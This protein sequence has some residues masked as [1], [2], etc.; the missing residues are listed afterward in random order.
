M[1]RGLI[2][3]AMPLSMDKGRIIRRTRQGWH[4]DSDHS[5][6]LIGPSLLD[7]DVPRPPPLVFEAFNNDTVRIQQDYGIKN[8]L[9]TGPTHCLPVQTQS[10]PVGPYGILHPPT[11]ED[12]QCTL[13]LNFSIPGENCIGTIP[14]EETSFSIAG[15]TLPLLQEFEGD[16][17][18][19]DEEDHAMPDLTREATPDTQTMSEKEKDTRY[20]ACPFYKHDPRRFSKP[21]WKSCVHP[22]YETM[23]RVKLVSIFFFF[24][25]QVSFKVFLLDLG[26]HYEKSKSPET[27]T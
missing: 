7:C 19:E 9:L 8:P 21:K 26:S 23:H 13:T 2:P 1:A 6:P 20:L 14:R 5:P 27:Y 24:F 17:C 22:G 18:V 12:R 11:L 4:P 25:Y 10:Q 3:P 16:T 15:N